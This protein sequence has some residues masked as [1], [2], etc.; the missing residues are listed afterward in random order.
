MSDFFNDPGYD[1]IFL[2]E[3]N[4]ACGYDDVLDERLADEM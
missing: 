1:D 2:D 4:E 3:E